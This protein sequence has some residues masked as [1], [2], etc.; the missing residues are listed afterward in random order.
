MKMTKQEALNTTVYFI[1]EEGDTLLV[2]SCSY[3]DHVIKF[4]DETTTPYGV[5]SVLFIRHVEAGEYDKDEYQLEGGEQRYQLCSWKPA[6][7]RKVNGTAGIY[8]IIDEYN[9]IEDAEDALFAAH[10]REME[11]VDQH[12]TW[13]T[14][15]KQEAEEELQERLANA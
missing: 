5:G 2:D 13:Y 14:Y 12:D 9:T 4:R 10:E 6:G 3:Y 7:G 1:A 8:W 11:R 15:S